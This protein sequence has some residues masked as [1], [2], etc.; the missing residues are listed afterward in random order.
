MRTHQ[1]AITLV[2][3]DP[4]QPES[5]HVQIYERLRHVITTGKL[6]PG[7]R[8]PSSRML[9][10]ELR[11]S[12]NTV[13]AAYAQLIAEGYADSRPGGGT[14]ACPNIADSG[15]SA[16]PKQK[17]LAASPDQSAVLSNRGRML[18][19]PDV[20]WAARSRTGMAFR[21]GAPAFDAFAFSLWSRITSRVLKRKSRSIVGYGDAAGYLPLREQVA[22]YLATARGVQCDLDQIVIV[23]GSQNALDL[24]ARMLIDPGDTVWIEEP[25]Y[26]GARAAFL[27]GGA[28][29]MGVP[30]DDE[31]LN[32]DEGLARAKN[33]RLIYVTR[34]HQFPLGAIMSLDRRA[35]LIA[36]AR[37]TTA[38]IVEDD[39]DSEFRYSGRPLQAL[40]GMDD[41]GH[42]IYVGTFSKVLFPALRLGYIVVPKPLVKAFNVARVVSGFHTA[43]PE[44][45]VLSE[46]MAEGH[47]VRHLRRMRELYRERQQILLEAAAAEL[48]GLVELAPSDAGMHLV[49]RPLNGRTDVEISAAAARDGID[50][51]PLSIYYHDNAPRNGLLLGYTGVRPPLIWS[52]ARDLASS[53]TRNG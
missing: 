8:L 38:W 27:G 28:N 2:H 39:Y 44:Q 53:M 30:V 40:Q 7:M 43:T 11:V 34:S 51:M 12:R 29:L 36:L 42:V 49:G 23:N 22:L 9:A 18:S 37:K 26:L 19:A 32:V 16:V 47:L 50:T 21:V 6:M 1:P 52:G 35:E 13:L 33:R 41:G 15:F 48:G 31:G 45:A 46:F 25:G 20:S 3:I 24:I 14:Y 10:V 17:T 5:L 4:T